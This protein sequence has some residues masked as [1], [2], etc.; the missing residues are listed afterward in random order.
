MKFAFKKS[1]QTKL[2]FALGLVIVSLTSAKPQP[3]NRVNFSGKWVLNLDKTELG[4]VPERAAVKQFDVKQ[5]RDSI[6]ITRVTINSND[7]E[8]TSSEIGGL[9]GT[10]YSLVLS[11][12]KTKTST[13]SWSTD[14]KEMTTVSRYSAP[15]NPDEIQYTLSQVWKLNE[16]KNQLI[17][18]LT[19]PSYTIKCV[20]DKV[21]NE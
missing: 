8:V 20:Y 12:G 17:I 11:D 19:S 16:E 9:D 4:N 7:E 13:I 21:N 6:Y 14:Q 10:P 1:L 18:M 3:S 2:I 15:N 5:A